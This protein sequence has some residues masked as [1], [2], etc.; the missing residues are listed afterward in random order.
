M[1][2][3]SSQKRH[4]TFHSEQEL[5][6]I[7]MKHNQEFIRNHGHDLDVSFFKLKVLFTFS[8]SKFS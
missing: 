3:Y 7:R 6:E 5:V 8:N 4:W 2:P 1:Y